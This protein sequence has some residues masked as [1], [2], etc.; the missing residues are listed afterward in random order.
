MI[1]SRKELQFYLMADRMMNRGTFK[2]T[3][4]QRLKRVIVPDLIMKYLYHMRKTSYYMSRNSLVKKFI[5]LYHMSRYKRLGIRLGFSI[6]YDVFGYGLV[7]PHH[8]TIVVG[9]SNRI[10]NYAVLH[11]STCISD[12]NKV[13]GNGLYL[14]TGAKMTSTIVL[15][16]NVS[17]AA[18]SVVNKSYEDGN[19]LIAG[20]PA[21]FKK[22][23]VAWYY[24]DGEYYTNVVNKCELLKKEMGL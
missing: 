20:A 8:G 1:N 2:I 19:C 23:E 18:N 13:V 24:R 10:G 14:S 22:A 5:G 4:M 15:G 17:V 11:T 6:G 21:V 9:S 12:N 3:L 16:D 7:V